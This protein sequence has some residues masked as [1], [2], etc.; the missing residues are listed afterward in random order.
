MLAFFFL[1]LSPPSPVR[2]CIVVF[3]QV[4]NVLGYHQPTY[5]F[6]FCFLP[7]GRIYN[8]QFRPQN[9]TKFQL[10]F[11]FWNGKVSSFKAMPL[12]YYLGENARNRG[13]GRNWAPMLFSQHKDVLNVHPL[14]MSSASSFSFLLGAMW[15]SVCVTIH[16]KAWDDGIELSTVMCRSFSGAHETNNIKTLRGMK[17]RNQVTSLH[18]RA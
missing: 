7:T 1:L 18:S 5:V 15:Y 13:R 16:E 3:S 9:T 11:W 8:M 10:L 2:D 6:W 14:Q 4:Y 17:R 12:I